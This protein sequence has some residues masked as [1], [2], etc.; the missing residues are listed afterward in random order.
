MSGRRTTAA[1][2]HPEA[3]LVRRL[4][5]VILAVVLLC[6]AGVWWF[7]LRDD[8]PPPAALGD[9]ASPA[10]SDA[11]D[12]PDGRWSLEPD[13]EREAVFVGYRIEE[14]FGGETVTKTATGRTSDVEGSL[15]VTDGEV[16]EASIV[17][18]LD[19]LRSDRTA[20][21]SA[22]RRRGLETDT[23]PEARF[24]LTAP[25]VLASAPTVGSATDAVATGTLELHGE[26]AEVDVPIEA[27]WTG[28]TIKLSG[29]APVVL[30]DYGIEQV[31]TPIVDIADHGE[32]EFELV[33]TP[34]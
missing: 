30:A 18:H 9:C 33:F 10:A 8:A 16:T 4:V 26:Q 23:F 28:P 1:P 6:G 24:T 21:D 22:M 29:S 14:R 15:V 3:G 12:T 25:I 17:A 27:C 5:V 19:S 20:R 32:L 31:Q 34:A 13:P 11:P 2:L 7:V